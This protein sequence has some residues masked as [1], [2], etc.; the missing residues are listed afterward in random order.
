[1][2]PDLASIEIWRAAC[3]VIP[4][5]LRDKIL[6]GFFTFADIPFWMCSTPV[7]LIAKFSNLTMA[8]TVFL[9]K[10]SYK[11][12]KLSLTLFMLWLLSLPI[13]MWKIFSL[14][15]ILFK[16]SWISSFFKAMFFNF[17]STTLLFLKMLF[18]RIDYSAA[19]GVLFA[20]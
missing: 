9:L 6:R 1:M 17:T 3:S 7:F 15:T 20:R 2:I 4:L 16:I 18:R 5:F 10:K 8:V 19:F 14:S 13:S 11:I 12:Y